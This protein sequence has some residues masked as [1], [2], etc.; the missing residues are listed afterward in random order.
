MEH[1]LILGA[2]GLVGGHCLKF[3]LQNDTFARVTALVRR[4]VP[5]ATRTV[6]SKLTW[7]PFDFKDP[8]AY[9]ALPAADAVFCCLGQPLNR[10]HRHRELLEVDCHYPLRVAHR[11]ASTGARHFAIVTSS[12]ISRYSPLYYCRVKAKVE[13]ELAELPF[14]GLHLFQPSLLLGERSDPH[15]LQAWWGRILTPAAPWFRGPL[16]R[17]RPVAAEAVGFAMVHAALQS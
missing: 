15:P 6:H 10:L 3:L 12:G 5:E 2:S 7:L 8:S 9:E 11:A 17:F 14:T 13:R 16:G 1:A 4:D